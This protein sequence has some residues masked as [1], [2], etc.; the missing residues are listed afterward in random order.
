MAVIDYDNI[1]EKSI[2][3][4]SF[5]GT[6]WDGSGVY[7]LNKPKLSWEAV[8]WWKKVV[9][10]IKWAYTLIEQN[11]DSIMQEV[12]DRQNA[13]NILSTQIAQTADEIVLKASQNAETKASIIVNSINGWNVL[14]DAKNIRID[15]TTTFGSWYDPSTKETPSWAQ[16][17]V[18]N[19][20]NRLWNLAFNDLVEASLLWTTIIQWWY[21]R[22][23]LLTADNILTWTLS[24]DRIWAW[25]ITAAT[26]QTDTSWQRV[27]ID[28]H[29]DRITFYNSDDINVWHLYGR[30]YSVTIWW[31]TYNWNLIWASSSFGVWTDLFVGD[32]ILVGDDVVIW[33]D[34]FVDWQVVGDLKMWTWAD[35]VLNST[36]NRIYWDSSKNYYIYFDGSN[37]KIKDINWVRT[38]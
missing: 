6:Q 13:D 23:N 7:W 15:W 5:A 24:A 27:I 19:L 16:S 29:N 32:D 25:T 30:R 28:N 34:L 10:D 11:K 9:W 18:D 20:A 33:W 26:L 38:L 8:Q 35:I 31:T 36:N 14:I 4:E 21:I 22:S 3:Q 12:V 17:K 2:Y 1:N 37:W